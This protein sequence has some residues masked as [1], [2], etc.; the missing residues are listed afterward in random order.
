MSY[1]DWK[2]TDPSNADYCSNGHYHCPPCPVGAGTVR[3]HP[4]CECDHEEAEQPFADSSFERFLDLPVNAGLPR[5]T[6]ILAT[7]GRCTNPATNGDVCAACE[8]ARDKRRD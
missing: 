2:T 6:W 4:C 8:D 1:D 3:E 7:T 5:C